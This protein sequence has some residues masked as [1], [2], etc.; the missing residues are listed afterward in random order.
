MIEAKTPTTTNFTSSLIL[1]GPSYY[2]SR[3]VFHVSGI[4]H[5]NLKLNKE[6]E[7]FLGDKPSGILRR[8]IEAAS[9]TGF[10][11]SL[12]APMW[13][14]PNYAINFALFDIYRKYLNP[15]NPNTEYWRFFLGNVAA[16]GAAGATALFITYPVDFARSRLSW[17]QMINYEKRQFTGLADYFLKV[18]KSKGFQGL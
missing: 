7:L 6:R 13:D 2:I 9:M 17:E 10:S 8:M 5:Y 4:F 11:Q 3:F 15:F 18:L 14:T 12:R 1:G 16:G